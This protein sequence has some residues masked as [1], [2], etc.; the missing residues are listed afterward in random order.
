[1]KFYKRCVL[2]H[3]WKVEQKTMT[4]SILQSNDVQS[5]LLLPFAF[6]LDMANKRKFICKRCGKVKMK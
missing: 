4:Q 1:M 2:G 3:K 6:L 5:M